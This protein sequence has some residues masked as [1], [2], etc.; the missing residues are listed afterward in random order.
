METTQKIYRKFM[1]NILDR[2]NKNRYNRKVE[3]LCNLFDKRK[4]TFPIYFGGRETDN[5]RNQS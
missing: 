4:S 1:Y 2:M 3:I 5:G